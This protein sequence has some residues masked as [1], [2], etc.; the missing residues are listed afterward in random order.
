MSRICFST[1][2]AMHVLDLLTIS[3]QGLNY[4]FPSRLISVSAVSVADQLVNV[5]QHYVKHWDR[6]IST[7]SSSR[8]ETC[9]NTRG[10]PRVQ[11][12]FHYIS[13]YLLLAL[14]TPPMS[15]CHSTRTRL[16]DAP[17][18]SIL[19]LLFLSFPIFQVYTP[20][21]MFGYLYKQFVTWLYLLT[22]PWTLLLSPALSRS[23]L[24]SAL[25]L[26]VFPSFSCLLCT[27]HHS[28]LCPF[29]F[30]LSLPASVSVSPST[31]GPLHSLLFRDF[32]FAFYF[33]SRSCPFSTSLFSR[34]HRLYPSVRLNSLAN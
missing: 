3:F 30:P 26:C 16:T 22:S 23:L 17:C 33:D 28:F 13:P 32:W 5:P 6:K 21:W 8:G 14:L 24:F 11:C 29:H 15:C 1:W 31:G 25:F 9:P 18:Y 20:I 12:F 34:A 2:R 7:H 10:L 19:S 27:L 4:S